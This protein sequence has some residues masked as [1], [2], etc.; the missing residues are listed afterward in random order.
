MKSK[1]DSSSNASNNDGNGAGLRIE[2]DADI[3]GS[4]GMSAFDGTRAQVTIYKTGVGDSLA[5]GVDLHVDACVYD[6]AGSEADASAPVTGKIGKSGDT[7]LGDRAH[8]KLRYYLESAASA[9]GIIQ[10]DWVLAYSY[11]S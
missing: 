11:T 9:G 3:P 10:W 7:A 1:G 5:N 6:N 8:V 4:L 2:H